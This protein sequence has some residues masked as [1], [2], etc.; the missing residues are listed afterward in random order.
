MSTDK[1]TDTSKNPR[2][3]S[4]PDALLATSQLGNIELTEE[5]LRRTAGG[6]WGFKCVP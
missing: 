3:T 2:Q 6:F 1:H 4:R 5:E